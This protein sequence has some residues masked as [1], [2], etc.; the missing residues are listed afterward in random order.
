MIVRTAAFLFLFFLIAPPSA[1]AEAP[2]RV[3]LIPADGGTESGTLHDYGPLFEAVGTLIGR[4]FIL[5]VGQNYGAVVE[6]MAAGQADIAFFGPA[7][8]LEARRR[9]AAE[10]LAVA[11]ENGASIYYA[12]IFV[13]RHSPAKN[14]TDLR[15][16]SVAFG[17]VN[18]TSS[19]LY[20]V[21]M[22]L[23][24]GLDPA[25][26]LGPVRLTGSHAQ[27]L[28]ALAAGRVDAAAASFDSFQKAVRE[29]AVDPKR[30]RLLARSEAIPYPPLALHP[31]LSAATK[32]ALRQAFRD[33]HRHPGI[34]AGMIR[35]YG[36]KQVER[37]DTDIT[38]ELFDRAAAQ[39]AQV[40]DALKTALMRKAAD[41]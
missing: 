20:P 39:I 29:G 24:A 33:V 34:Q 11:V 22:L 5:R 13:S 9:G 21:A 18:S 41:R 38:D 15:G 26:D 10:L 30:V 32:T 14:L 23:A 37:Y 2:L 8:Y 31:A 16:C 17:D 36:G 3:V 12:G 40:N 19:F 28:T 25:R 35:G 7:S 6:A 1:S 4:E 27:A